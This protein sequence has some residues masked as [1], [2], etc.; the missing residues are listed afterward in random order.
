MAISG[1]QLNAEI[2]R[3]QT[4]RDNIIFALSVAAVSNEQ[5]AQLHAQLS[6]VEDRL[7]MLTGGLSI[8]PISTQKSG[9]DERH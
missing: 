3:L 2:I 9:D 6:S 5:R 4:Q 7:V 8:H 1:D